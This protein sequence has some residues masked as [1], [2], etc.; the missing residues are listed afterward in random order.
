MKTIH[1]KEKVNIELTTYKELKKA[2]YVHNPF[3]ISNYDT[4]KWV[5]KEEKLIIIPIEIT[6]QVAS[7]VN[8]SDIDRILYNEL[9]KKLSKGCAAT[10]LVNIFNNY[11]IIHNEINHRH[12]GEDLTFEK[13]LKLIN[14][15]DEYFNPS[16]C[17]LTTDF[18]C[19]YEF[20]EEITSGVSVI[21]QM[22]KQA[23][24]NSNL[25]E[26]RSKCQNSMKFMNIFN[27]CESVKSFDEVFN[28]TDIIRKEKL[29]EVEIINL[30]SEED[31]IDLSRD[32]E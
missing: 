5:K 28:L 31:E 13:R 4:D 15:M 26:F 12:I 7:D 16:V 19:I 9:Y 8:K 20:N 25:M 23:L 32:E 14:V 10:V 11:V 27:H 6:V 17:A 3:T 24:I 1:V 21:K 29:K 22:M 18:R 2:P 30:V